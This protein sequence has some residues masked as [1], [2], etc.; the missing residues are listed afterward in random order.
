VVDDTKER[1]RGEEVKNDNYILGILIT[2]G[3][4]DMAMEGTDAG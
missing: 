3:N 2:L 4:G 1:E